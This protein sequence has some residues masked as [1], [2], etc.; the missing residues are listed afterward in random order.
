MGGFRLFQFAEV[1]TALL[2]CR[3]LEIFNK[4]FEMFARHLCVRVV[5]FAN[6]FIADPPIQALKGVSTFPFNLTSRDPMEG[7]V[8][9]CQ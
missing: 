2:A 6:V 8:R 3:F 1:L 4:P 9:V 5:A 7:L